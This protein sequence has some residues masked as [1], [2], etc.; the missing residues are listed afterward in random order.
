MNAITATI[1]GY[2]LITVLLWGTALQL[3]VTLKGQKRRAEEH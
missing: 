2:C 3:F 1:V